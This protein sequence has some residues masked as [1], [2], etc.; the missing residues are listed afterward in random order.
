MTT[1]AFASDTSVPVERTQQEIIA[2]L[3]EWEC[4][5]I[6]WAEDFEKHIVVLEFTWRAPSK[7]IYRMH[8][9]MHLPSKDPRTDRPLNEDKRKQGARSMHRLLLLKLKAD[10]NAVRA[11]LAKAEE[12]FLPWMVDTNGKTIAE[13]LIPQLEQKF[14]ALPPKAGG[15]GPNG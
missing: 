11:G 14:K 3:R 15:P 2:L 1:R 13:F 10:L 8:F 4:G 6:Q 9:E 12:I 5:S 7:A